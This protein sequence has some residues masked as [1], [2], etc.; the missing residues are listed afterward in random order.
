VS[1][2]KLQVKVTKQSDGTETQHF[3]KKAWRKEITWDLCE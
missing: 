2:I 1:L 3:N